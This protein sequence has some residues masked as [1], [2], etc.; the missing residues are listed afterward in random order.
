MCA[1]QMFSIKVLSIA[2]LLAFSILVNMLADHVLFGKYSLALRVVCDEFAHCISSAVLWLVVDWIISLSTWNRRVALSILCGIFASALDF[3]H[4]F[5]A[6]SFTLRAVLH[7]R[8][9]PLFHI[10]TFTASLNVLLYLLLKNSPHNYLIV[11]VFL[12]WFPHQTR[13]ANRRGYTM[14]P[15]GTTPPLAKWLYLFMLAL[16]CPVLGVALFRLLPS[17]V[18]TVNVQTQL[19]ELRYV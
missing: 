14:Y 2:S 15:F 8:T 10:T 16:L 11:F 17:N 6:D 5:Q 18:S 1:W 19:P 4:I 13:D 3:D 12:I 7:L 9:R